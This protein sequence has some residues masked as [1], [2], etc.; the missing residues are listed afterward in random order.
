MET[1]CT[2]TNSYRRVSLCHSL[3]LNRCR[4]FIAYH[5]WY[6]C[7][8][9]MC[10]DDHDA[11]RMECQTLIGHLLEVHNFFGFLLLDSEAY[12]EYA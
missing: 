10:P 8:A 1:R 3:P 12:G 11:L 4:L 6:G 5:H 2:R 9:C 7:I